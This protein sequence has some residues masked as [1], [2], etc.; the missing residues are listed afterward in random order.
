M[1]SDRD[2]PPTGH[3][4]HTPFICS[5]SAVS[6]RL[7][8]VRKHLPYDTGCSIV[9]FVEGRQDRARESLGVSRALLWAVNLS[10]G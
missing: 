6:E 10:S 1:S 7:S 5:P 4:V 3:D 8:P 9:T 2:P